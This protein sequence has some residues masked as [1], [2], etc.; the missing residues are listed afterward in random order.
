MVLATLSS[1]RPARGVSAEEP[2]QGGA[3]GG[4]VH[5]AGD[6]PAL[7]LLR[8]IPQADRSWSQSFLFGVESGNRGRKEGFSG[9][10][11]R[12]LA[13]PGLAC[14]LDAAFVTW[15]LTL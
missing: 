2:R 4:T 12:S 13:S 11:V 1:A 14:F 8:R 15:E 6:R 5:G 7:Q 9:S 10:R 3:V